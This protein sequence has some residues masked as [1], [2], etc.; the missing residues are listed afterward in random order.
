MA[1]GG[2]SGNGLGTNDGNFQDQKNWGPIPTGEYT[3][4]PSN[5][6]HGA[7]SFPLQPDEGNNV[8]GRP[9]GFYIHGDSKKYPG[10]QVASKGCIIANNET[11]QQISNS[12]DNDLWVVP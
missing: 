9:G 8:D 3:I 4:L 6:K 10:M 2:Y 12:N 1:A 7:L 5:N 11:R